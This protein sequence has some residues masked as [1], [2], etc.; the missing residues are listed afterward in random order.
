MNLYDE[1]KECSPIDLRFLL[2][3]DPKEGTQPKA[4][5]VIQPWTTIDDKW[6]FFQRKIVYRG[7]KG[8]SGCPNERL[9]VHS[10]FQR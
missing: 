6:D 7:R 1:T 8:E 3:T 4:C 9:V 10:A 5:H 2:V